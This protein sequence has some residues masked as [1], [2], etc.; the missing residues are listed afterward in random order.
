MKRM[1]WYCLGA[2]TLLWQWVLL[3]VLLVGSLAAQVK[4]PERLLR[5][6]VQLQQSGHYSEAIVKYRSYLE[7]H[8]EAAAVRSN[9]GAAL[10]H[11]GRYSE[12]VREY[13]LALAVQPA[14]YGIRLNL[15]L[16][17]YKMGEIDQAVKEFEAVYAVLPVDDP[18]RRRLTLLLSECY[19]REGADERV[20]ALLDPLVETAPDDLA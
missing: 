10:A 15:G 1:G 8:P 6:A 11:E 19:L 18:E 7:A 12:A 14:N 9:L 4:S 16:A 17:D 20:V 3:G 5:Q 13:K 2:G